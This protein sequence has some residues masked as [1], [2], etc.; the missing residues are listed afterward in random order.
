M[1]LLRLRLPIRPTANKSNF[2]KQLSFKLKARNAWQSLACS[3]RGIEVTPIA[4]NWWNKT[5]YWSSQGL[6][7]APASER[8][9]TADRR[10]GCASLPPPKIRVTGPTFTTF[11]TMCIAK[12]CSLNLSKSELRHSN[13]FRNDKA[14]NEGESADFAHFNPKL[15]TSRTLL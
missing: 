2:N 6:A 9:Q 10:G 4:N 7:V 3:P 1:L 8:S 13:P 11:Y 15:N 14:P 12:L 5:E